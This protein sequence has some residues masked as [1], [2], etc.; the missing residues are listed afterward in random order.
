MNIVH[1]FIR[2]VVEVLDGPDSWNVG[3]LDYGLKNQSESQKKL[4]FSFLE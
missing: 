4:K 2:A 3:T 1:L